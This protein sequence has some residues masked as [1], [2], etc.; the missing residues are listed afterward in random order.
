MTQPYWS[1]L[2]ICTALANSA[3]LAYDIPTHYDL[4]QTAVTNS[5]VKN[6]RPARLILQIRWITKY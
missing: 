3:A 6:H 1:V 2:G 5:N 4:S